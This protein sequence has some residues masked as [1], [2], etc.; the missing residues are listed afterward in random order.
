MGKPLAA[1]VSC[2]RTR[3]SCA[4]LR[5]KATRFVRKPHATFIAK[6][7]FPRTQISVYADFRVRRFPC[8]QIS[9][10]ADFRVRGFPTPRFVRKPPLFVRKQHLFV[11]KPHSV[12][13]IVNFVDVEATA[14]QMRSLHYPV[15]NH[16]GS[17][18]TTTSF[19]NPTTLS[20]FQTGPS[21]TMEL[22]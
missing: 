10:Y 18:L 3:V 11:R 7:R 17:V 8:T 4:T 1:C 9:V 15:L 6:A 5:A 12:K 13:F 14:T 22:S 2:P 21:M 19:P 16:A 20:T